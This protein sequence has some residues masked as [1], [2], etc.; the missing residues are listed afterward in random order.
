MVTRIPSVPTVPTSFTHTAQS[1]PIGSSTF[2]QGFP[3]NGGH[4][5]SSTPYIGPPPS[6]VGVQFG[7][8]N[9]Y[10]QGFQT[11]VSA[12]FMS[13][14]FSLFSG[15]ILA[16]V[17][18]TPI[19]TGAAR[20][21]YIVPYTNNHV[22]YGWNPF[23]SNP[24]TSQ[25]AAGGNPTFTYGKRGKAPLIPKLVLLMLRLDPRFPSWQR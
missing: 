10:G 23:Q 7:N 6:Y 12:P 1:G 17:F 18:Q 21:S 14:P 25:L 3:W 20:A 15:G 9:P 4:I 13:S 8:T 24:S 11:S 2:V 16:P 19:S 5:S 22:A